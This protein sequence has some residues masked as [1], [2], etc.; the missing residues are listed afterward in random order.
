[1]GELNGGP[2]L[3]VPELL[4]MPRRRGVDEE[5]SQLLHE[6]VCRQALAWSR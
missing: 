3:P 5:A 1:M 6:D 2:R 4:S